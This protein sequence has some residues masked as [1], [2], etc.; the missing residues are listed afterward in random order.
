[1]TAG[2][3]RSGIRGMRILELTQRFPPALGGV[4]RYVERLGRELTAAGA[5]VEVVT[6]DLLRDRPFSREEFPDSPGPVRVRRHRAVLAVP[7]PH[8]VGIVVPGMLSD[9]LRSQ[10]DVVHAHAFGHFPLWAGRLARAL[11]GVPL[12][13]TPHSDPGT[14]T[15]RSQLWSR[16]EARST[17]HGADRTVALS[18]IEATWLTGLGV[19][20]ERIRV[21][22]AGIDRSEFIG[23]RRTDR[24]QRAATVLFVGRLDLAQK[25]LEPLVRAMALLP[26]DLGARLRLVGED[27]GGRDRVLSLARSLGIEDRVNALGAISRKDLL[28]E[29]ASADLLVLPSLFD[30]FPVVV[31]EAMAAGLPVVA[32]RVGGVPEIVAEGQTG[33]IV[34]PGDP[35]RLADA[36]RAVLSDPA[37]GAEWGEEGRRR[38]A[39]FDWSEIVPEYVRLFSEVTAGGSPNLAG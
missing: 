2:S 8:G 4:E 10:V 32:T 28:G 11:R 35:E 12:V 22:P 29:Y 23:I 13:V 9:A 21:I 27:W 6:S 38:S 14:G 26:A 19:P 30:S 37:K 20:V 1:M 25:G 18:Q 34:P 3:E 24:R 7:A 5:S 15:P 31:I 16:F 17:V 33:L 36:M 39:R